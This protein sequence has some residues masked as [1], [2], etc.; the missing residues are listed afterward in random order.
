MN[1]RYDMLEKIR[2]SIIK[3][4]EDYWDNG[5][6]YND[7]DLDDIMD[8]VEKLPVKRNPAKPKRTIKA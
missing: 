6:L 1:N 3:F 2:E 8:M 7:G 5:G 4:A